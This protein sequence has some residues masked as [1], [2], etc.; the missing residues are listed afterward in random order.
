[1][2]RTIFMK[3][4]VSGWVICFVFLCLMGCNDGQQ[5]ENVEEAEGISRFVPYTQSITTGHNEFDLLFYCDEEDKSVWVKDKID[6][7]SIQIG[8]SNTTVM[9]MENVELVDSGDYYKGIMKIT[10]EFEQE[11]S[12]DMYLLVSMKEKGKQQK[13]ELGK[14]AVV[15]NSRTDYSDITQMQ[16]GGVVKMDEKENVYTYGVI[17][18]VETGRDISIKKIDLALEHIGLATDQ[19]VIYSHKE[20]KEKIENSLDETT[21]DKI[22]KDA[23][24]KKRV[25][26]LNNTIDLDLKKGEYYI[27]FPL[28]F[29][30]NDTPGLVQSVIRIQYTNGTDKEKGFVSNCFP[31]FSEFS[32]NETVVKN[33]F[34]DNG[35]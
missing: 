20:Y 28:V 31:Y 15:D 23:Y 2:Q 22:C 3:K 16:C 26:F 1:M 4:F 27:Y 29:T 24:I 11:C 10:G 19:Y 13:Y 32:K 6:E 33:M 17:T 14:C 9:S 34:F 7:V 8:K 21:F 35:E 5:K 12:G 25:D 30:E 18:H